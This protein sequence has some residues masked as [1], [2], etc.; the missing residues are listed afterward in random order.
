MR[1]TVPTV[2]Q[3]LHK[4]MHIFFESS[5]DGGECDTPCTRCCFALPPHSCSRLVQLSIMVINSIHTPCHLLLVQWTRYAREGRVTRS[6]DYLRFCCPCV[7]SRVCRRVCV[8]V[9][10]QI[11]TRVLCSSTLFDPTII[12]G[13]WAVV[14]EW[15]LSIKDPTK[16]GLPA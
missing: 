4:L 8:V 12:I 5:L 6:I 2:Y 1:L 16:R 9:S 15:L 10:Y 3:P 11:F 13:K 14:T 7:V